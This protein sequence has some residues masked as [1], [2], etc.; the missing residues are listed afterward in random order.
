MQPKHFTAASL[1]LAGCLLAPTFA[2][3]AGEAT[4]LWSRD[5][6][7]MILVEKPAGEYGVVL[8]LSDGR[9]DIGDK[10]EG[11][12]ESINQIR[13]IKNL[14]SGEEIMMRG[15]RYSTSR[16]YVLQVMPKWCKAPKE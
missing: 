11:D 7:E 8:R 1:L 6:C 10:L 5:R 12:F 9:V 14:A 2:A 3:Q 13:N 4:I 15:V 16:K